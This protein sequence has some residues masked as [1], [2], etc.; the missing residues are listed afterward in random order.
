L[1]DSGDNYLD[2]RRL[3][4]FFLRMAAYYALAVV[5]HCAL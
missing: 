3:L 2:A 1:H 4:A 5:S